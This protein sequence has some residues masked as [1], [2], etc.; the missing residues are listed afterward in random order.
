MRPAWDGLLLAGE[1]S[2]D[3]DSCAEADGPIP[4]APPTDGDAAPG[5]ETLG[6]ARVGDGDAS[7]AD[8]ATLGDGDASAADGATDGGGVRWRPTGSGPAKT[9]AARRPTATSTP[10]SRP[11]RIVSPVLIRREGT[12]TDGPRRLRGSAASMPVP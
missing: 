7:S 3:P 10:A 6:D 5:D 11:A 1:V 12:S 4:S 9:S 2:G 8:G